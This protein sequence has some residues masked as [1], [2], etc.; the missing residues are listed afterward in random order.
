MEFV[1]SIANP[2][3]KKENRYEKDYDSGHQRHAC[4]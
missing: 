2:N 1:C 4:R 3:K